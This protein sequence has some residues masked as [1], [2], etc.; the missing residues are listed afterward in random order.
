M[1]VWALCEAKNHGYVVAGDNL[2]T[3][4]QWTKERLKDIDKPRDTRP[5]WNMVSTPA[6]AAMLV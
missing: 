5:G 1:T 6:A 4:V 2:A 3:T